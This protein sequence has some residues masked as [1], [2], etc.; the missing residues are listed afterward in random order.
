M[1]IEEQMSQADRGRDEY[2]P[3][4]VHAILRREEEEREGVAL[5]KATKSQIESVKADVASSRVEVKAVVASLRAEVAQLL[6]KLDKH[7]EQSAP[8]VAP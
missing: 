2:F 4:F 6:L 3:R 5:H 8:A 1:S 7:L